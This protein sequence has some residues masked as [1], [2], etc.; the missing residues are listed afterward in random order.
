MISN[1]FYSRNF[2]TGD[3]MDHNFAN[4]RVLMQV[5]DKKVAI[6]KNINQTV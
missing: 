2:P 5:T 4:M 1:E 6:G 3:Q